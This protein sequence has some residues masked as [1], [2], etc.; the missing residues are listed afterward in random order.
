MYYVYILLCADESYYVGMTHDLDQRLAQHEGH[1]F[2]NAYTC[3]RLPVQMVWSEAFADHDEAFRS[4]RQLKGWSHAKK[5]ALVH[6]GFEEVHEITRAERKR[7]E[8]R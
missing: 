4:E 3:S 1:I 2:E 6:G 8:G 5:Q 7:R